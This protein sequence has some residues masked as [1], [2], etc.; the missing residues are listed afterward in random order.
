MRLIQYIVK[1]LIRRL[2]ENRGDMLFFVCIKKDEGL[3]TT[4][5]DAGIIRNYLI[6]M[7]KNNPTF[8]HIFNE[9]VNHCLLTMDKKDLENNTLDN[10]NTEKTWK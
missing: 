2:D 5:G 4:Y 7:C 8:Y 6:T 10:Q 3:C 9:V 1:R